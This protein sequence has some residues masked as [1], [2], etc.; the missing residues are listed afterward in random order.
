[1]KRIST[2]SSSA[3]RSTRPAS[4]PVTFNGTIGLFEPAQGY[5]RPTAVLFANPW[6]LEDM[7]TRKFRRILAEELADEGIASLRFDYPFTGNALDDGAETA[8][9]NCWISAFSVAAQLVA[10]LSG[11]SRIVIVAQG[12][13]S[14]VA[15]RAM[16]EM[17]G[18]DAIVHLAPVTSGRA[19]VRELSMMSQVIKEKLDI[20]ADDTGDDGLVVA[21]IGIPRGIVEDLKQISLLKQVSAT[22]TRMLV[23]TRDTNPGDMNYVDHLRRIGA[24]V[25]SEIFDGYEC[26]TTNPTLA[27]VS[28]AVVDKVVS[29]IAALYSTGRGQRTADTVTSSPHNGEGFTE[30]PVRFGTNN[31][32]VGILCTPRVAVAGKVAALLLSSG[33]DP[34]S[35]WARSS[36]RLARSLAAQGISSLRFDGAN[37]A[38]SPP[39]MGTSQQVLYDISQI[40]DVEDAVTLLKR[41]EP[42]AAILAVGRCSGAH[43]GF[44][45][46]RQNEQ[47]SGLVAVNP[48]VFEWPEGRSVDEALA[49][50]VQSMSHYYQRLQGGEAFKRL[51]RGEVDIAVK[52]KQVG[53]AVFRKL[54]APAVRLIGGM[55]R[56]ERSVYSGFRL[57]AQRS[58]PVMLLYSANDVGLDEFNLFFGQEGDGLKNFPNIARMIVDNADHNFTPRHAFDQYLQAII[59][60]SNTLSGS[61]MMF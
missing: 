17:P 45:A 34:M 43:L 18:V 2:A 40:I 41:Y 28:E 35:G 36:V 32:L 47:I 42:Q 60:M 57:L 19:Y 22:R 48:V 52:T 23:F 20:D 33:Y 44:Q 7:C 46:A 15:A 1:M 39:M 37:V 50:P 55:T 5:A 26:L 61:G 6:G 21:G 8:N 58:A 11:C 16:E 14:L 31:R 25:Q 10:Q 3:N 53:Q 24:D 56:R 30:T 51:L 54:A 13:G 12:I 49:Q 59:D 29:W 27:I 9:L 38:D 4:V